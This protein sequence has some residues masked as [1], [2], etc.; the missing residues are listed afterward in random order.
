MGADIIGMVSD[1]TD[2][3]IFFLLNVFDHNV[4]IS[5]CKIDFISF[6]ID[7]SYGD[8]VLPE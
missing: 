8:S 1:N 3:F 7:L 4:P 2:S 6:A 5:N